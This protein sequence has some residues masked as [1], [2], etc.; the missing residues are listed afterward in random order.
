MEVIIP[1]MNLSHNEDYHKLTISEKENFLSFVFNLGENSLKR[2]FKFP[3]ENFS[4]WWFSLIAVKSPFRSDYYEKLISHLSTGLETDPL[5]SN[6]RKNKGIFFYFFRG[7]LYLC[8]YFVRL[9]KIQVLLK[10]FKRRKRSLSSMD[11]IIVSYFPLIDKVKAE[12]SIFEN[13]YLAPFHRILDEK[14]KD[15]YAHICLQ[16]TIDGYSFEDAIKMANQFNKNQTVFFLEEFVKLS[17]VFLFIFY[18]YYFMLVFLLNIKV[19]RHKTI[20]TYKGKS[21]NTWHILKEDFYNSFCGENLV[22]SVWF[23][24][25][26]RELTKLIKQDSKIIAICEMQWWEKALYLFAKKRGI[27]TIGFQH[28]IVPELVFNYFN[29]PQEF[30]GN[31]FIESCPLPDY[32]ATVGDI[33]AQLLVKYGWPQE[34]VFVWGAQRFEDLKNLKGSAL[35]WKDRKNYLVCALPMDYSEMCKVLLMLEGA[36]KELPDYK[37][38][39]KNHPAGMNL[40]QTIKKLGLNLSSVSFEITEEPLTDILKYAKAM[41]VTES[42]S[43]LY[44]VA[45]GIPVIVLRFIDKLDYNPLSYIS[46][47]PVYV[48]SPEELRKVCD[49]VIHSSEPPVV[50][51][52]WGIFLKNYFYFPEDKEE[53]L[54]KIDG[55][56]YRR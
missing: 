27:M 6:N 9:V 51:D 5:N 32:L 35:D 12:K 28:C 14:R 34:R 23:I 36:F 21:Y 49:K 16:S 2:I 25:L 33:T 19:I 1:S 38:I 40:S 24:L 37:I 42:S 3:G 20:Y 7:A 30:A 54:E 46:D 39:L 41:L 45:Y 48:Y 56:K 26:F 55:L 13:R 52:E 31:N 53:Y 10:D 29:I 8:Y 18:Y 43:S 11:Y 15:N 17:H 50:N 47:I 44:A 22:T 4:L